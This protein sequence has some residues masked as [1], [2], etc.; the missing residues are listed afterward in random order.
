[1]ES[2]A[3]HPIGHV[4][5]IFETKNGTPRQSG[6]SRYARASLT[7]SKQVFTNPEHSLEN[8]AEFSHVWLVWVFHQDNVEG[9]KVKAK[10]A[11]PRLG[12]AR[13]GVFST[14]SPHRPCNIGL[15][16]A[17]VEQVKGDTL[18]MSGV[19]LVDGTPVLDIKPFIPLYDTP[20]GVE[21][22]AYVEEECDELPTDLTNNE[23]DELVN[24]SPV[25]VPRAAKFSDKFE[26]EESAPRSSKISKE[27]C[28]RVGEPVEVRV[29]GW[30]GDPDEVRVPSWVGDP[31]EDLRVTFTPQAMSDLAELDVTQVCSWLASKEE[32]RGAVVD[33]LR[34]DPRS[35][36]R[37]N[38]CSDRLYFTTVDKVHVTA[39]YDPRRGGVMEVLRMVRA[40]SVG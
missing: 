12:G 40:D 10:V 19:D 11:P 18:V 34:A 6:L 5:S 2:F 35:V 27:D 39:W 15:T 30:V 28:D 26:E 4:K 13:V 29:P 14:R 32:V 20:G 37:K 33:L 9:R 7:V 31:D 16:L 38:S 17:R 36:Y 23:E 21:E 3:F 8:L 25:N 24:S 22:E 1:M